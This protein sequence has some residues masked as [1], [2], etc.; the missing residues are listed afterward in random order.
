M[1]RV[2][3]VSSSIDTYHVIQRGIDKRNIFLFREDYEKFLFYIMKAKEKCDFSI[4]AYCLMTNHVHLLIKVEEDTIGNIMRRITVGYAQY[5]NNKYDRNGHLFQNR[6]IS[7]PIEDTRYFLTV[8][9][10]IHQNPVKSGMVSSISDYPWSSYHAYNGNNNMNI[11]TIESALGEFHTFEN[12]KEFIMAKCGSTCIKYSAK[13]KY[14]DEELFK[15]ISVLFDINR[16]DL[17]D[18]HSRNEIIIKIKKYTKASNR[19]LARV[20][21]IGR[22]ILDRIK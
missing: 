9:R 10:Y 5:H 17:V 18:I 16:L 1:P 22:N 11:V 15:K 4:Y 14:T 7:E 13:T 6:F 21:G 8:L 19:Q 12:F 2:P 20:L 3:R